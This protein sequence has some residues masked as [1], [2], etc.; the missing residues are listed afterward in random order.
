MVSCCLLLPVSGGSAVTTFPF[1]L[2]APLPRVK[3]V[4]GGGGALDDVSQLCVF[5]RR[6]RAGRG[7]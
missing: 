2:I 7:F 3:R 4:E 5:W 6:G 1:Q